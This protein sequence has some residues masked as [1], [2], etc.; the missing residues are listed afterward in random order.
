[1]KMSTKTLSF[2]LKKRVLEKKQNNIALGVK[3]T[4]SKGNA[5]PMFFGFPPSGIETIFDVME[6]YTITGVRQ[7]KS[8]KR[9]SKSESYM[10]ALPQ[11]P[12]KKVSIAE[13][14]GTRMINQ[15]FGVVSQYK[16][17]GIISLS[18]TK[19]VIKISFL[20][21]SESRGEL[22]N[23]HVDRK[24]IYYLDDK[25]GVVEYMKM[26]TIS[27]TRLIGSGFPIENEVILE[28]TLL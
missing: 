1:M 10:L 22:S 17:E 4:G 20:S 28:E 27:K 3:I 14:W 18:K 24:G 8:K 12:D 19:K 2:L 25:T 15:K 6:N 26:H 7:L 9:D 16:I 5:E 13:T 23:F 11:L 21:V